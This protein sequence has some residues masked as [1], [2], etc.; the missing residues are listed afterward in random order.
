ML[1][2]TDLF[3]KAGDDPGPEVHQGALRCERFVFSDTII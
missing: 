3:L 2:E 1:R